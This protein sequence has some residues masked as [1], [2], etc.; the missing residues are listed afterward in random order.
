MKAFRRF[1]FVG[2]ALLWNIGCE[3]KEEA[4]AFKGSVTVEQATTVL[5]LSTFPL[6]EGAKLVWP[7]GV[8]S[9]S[10]EGPGDVTSAFSAIGVEL[11]AR[12]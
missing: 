11:E 4:P 3:R 12:K 1:F 8:A 2:C 10:Y 7:R 5:D 6:I 9:L